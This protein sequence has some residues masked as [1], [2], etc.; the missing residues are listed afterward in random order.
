[1]AVWKKMV[2]EQDLHGENY[3]FDRDAGQQRGKG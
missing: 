1:M 3:F 2:K